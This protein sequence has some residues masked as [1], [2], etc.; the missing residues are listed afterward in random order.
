MK[1][2]S[3]LYLANLDI[4]EVLKSRILHKALAKEKVM[5]KCHKIFHSN[6]KHVS[7]F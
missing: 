2:G 1:K 3:S 5:K 4:V 7:Q 6:E